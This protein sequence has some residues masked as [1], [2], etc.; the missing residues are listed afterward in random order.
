MNA[1]PIPGASVKP[2][3][4][5]MT[6]WAI[7]GW[8]PSSV[9]IQPSNM[10]RNPRKP[11]RVNAAKSGPAGGP[12]RRRPLPRHGRA[13]QYGEDPGGTGESQRG[14]ERPVGGHAAAAPVEE[15]EHRNESG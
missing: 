15:P 1:M 7:Q 9:T 8:R 3:S 5:R 10:A 11:E 4:I 12:P 13:K 14:Q 2:S 6:P